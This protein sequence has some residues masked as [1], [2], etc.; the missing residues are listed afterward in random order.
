MIAGKK[1]VVSNAIHFPVLSHSYLISTFFTKKKIWSQHLIN[2]H[3]L[4]VINQ[5]KQIN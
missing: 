2:T 3:D 1:I 4:N 5:G